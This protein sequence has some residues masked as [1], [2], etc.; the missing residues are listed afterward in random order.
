MDN[1]QIL[2]GSVKKMLSKNTTATLFIDKDS[3]TQR[4]HP[5]TKLSHFLLSGVAVYAGPSGWKYTGL[6]LLVNAV[7]VASGGILKEACQAL[8]RIMLPLLLF[9]IPIHGFFYPDNKTVLFDAYGMTMY[10]EGLIFALTTLSCSIALEV[11]G[12]KSTSAKTSLRIL[13]D[14]TLQR[15]ARWLMLAGAATIVLFRWVW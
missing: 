9:T 3:W 4:L 10:Q 6:L 1:N 7:V 11:R 8:G 15:L 12:F 13:A 14:S 2:S 5:F